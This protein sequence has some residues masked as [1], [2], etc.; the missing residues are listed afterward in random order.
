MKRKIEAFL[1]IVRKRDGHQPEFM[2][3][4]EEVAE[5]VIPYIAENNIY[6]GKN[7]LM[8]MCEAERAITFRV[9]WVDDKGEFWVIRGY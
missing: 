5:T 7:I 1:N 8:R 2:Q 9:S 4:V 6:N 3:A